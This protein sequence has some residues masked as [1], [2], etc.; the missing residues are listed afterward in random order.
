MSRGGLERG[1]WLLPLAGDGQLPAFLDRSQA[2]G[3]VTA[4]LLQHDEADQD[5]GDVADHRLIRPAL[6]GT[7]PGVLLGIPEDGLHLPPAC[8]RTTTGARSAAGSL[9]TR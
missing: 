5:Q 4:E 8:L 9:V 2:L 6:A 3:R 1:W 7:Q